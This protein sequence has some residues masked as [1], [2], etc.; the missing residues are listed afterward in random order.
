MTPALRRLGPLALAVALL[1]AAARPAA[2]DGA[3][4]VDEGVFAYAGCS[5]PEEIIW[6]IEDPVFGDLSI[7]CN[8]SDSYTCAPTRPPPCAA[9]RHRA[10]VQLPP[11]LQ[12]GP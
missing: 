10:V 1:A 11:Q 12:Q 6:A 8:A 3:V 5:L 9:R 7:G 4:K 2:A